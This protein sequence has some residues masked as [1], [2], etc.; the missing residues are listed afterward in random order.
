MMKLRSTLRRAS[1]RVR[2]AAARWRYVGRTFEQSGLALRVERVEHGPTFAVPCWTVE[3]RET[4]TVH[5]LSFYLE[6]RPM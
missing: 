6:R 5:A 3:C 1:S 2:L 4:L